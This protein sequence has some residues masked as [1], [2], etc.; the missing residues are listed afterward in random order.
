MGYAMRTD[1]YRYVQWRDMQSSDAQP[2]SLASRNF[3]VTNTVSQE[4]LYDHL[5]DPKENINLSANPAYD[6]L[7]DAYA[8]VVAEALS[9]GYSNVQNVGA[10]TAAA[11]AI[12]TATMVGDTDI[13][14]TLN[15]HYV[16]TDPN[17]DPDTGTT[18]EWVVDDAFDGSYSEVLGSG[19]SYVLQAADADRFIKLRVTPQNAVVPTTG[20][21]VYSEW[22]VVPA[23]GFNDGSSLPAPESAIYE[24][25]D[26]AAGVLNSASAGGR[27]WSGGWFGNDALSWGGNSGSQ[28]VDFTWSNLPAGYHPTPAGRAGGNGANAN[29]PYRGLGASQTI[30]LAQDST[31]YFSYLYQHNGSGATFEKRFHAGTAEVFKL[32][33]N[34]SGSLSLI[35]AD[36]ANMNLLTLDANTAYVIV[37]RLLSVASGNDS[38][39][40]SI[41]KAGDTV[42]DQVPVFSASVN[43]ASSATLDRIF[44]GNPFNASNIGNAQWDEFHMDSNYLAVVGTD[45]GGSGTGGTLTPPTVEESFDYAAG[46]ISSASAGGTGWN[47]GWFGNNDLNWGGNSGSAAADKSWNTP[48]GYNF[49]PSGRAATNSTNGN[50]PYRGLAAGTQIDLS[51]DTVY[52]SFLFTHAS[53]STFEYRFYAGATDVAKLQ[54][55]SSG[56]L[57]LVGAGFVPTGFN[58][59]AGNDYLIVGRIVGNASGDDL[60]QVTAYPASG[61][62]P[63]SEV[64]FAHSALFQSSAVIDRILMGIPG[65]TVTSETYWDELRMGSNWG[66]VL[67]VSDGNEPDPEPVDTAPEASRLGISGGRIAGATLQGHYLYSDLEN[68]EENGSSFR[69]LSADT[70]DGSYTA[71]SAATAQSYTLQA[72]DLGK[73]IRFEVTPA[74]AASQGAAGTAV[75]SSPVW[76]TNDISYGLQ[77]HLEFE[78]ADL[79]SGFADS[80]GNNRGASTGTGTLI[81]RG[82]GQALELNGIDQRFTLPFDGTIFDEGLSVAFWAKGDDTLMPNGSALAWTIKTTGGNQSNVWISPGYNN[83]NLMQIIM[84]HDGSG[85]EQSSYAADTADIKG[86]WTHWAFVKNVPAGTIE[87][88]KNGVLVNTATGNHTPVYVEDHW[89]TGA[90]WA[91]GEIWGNFYAGAIDDYRIYDRQITEGEVAQIHN[92]FSTTPTAFS[93]NISGNSGV[94]D[95]LTANYGFAY[96]LGT[97]GTSTYQWYRGDTEFGSFTAIPGATS[98]TYTTTLDDDG[99]FLRFGVTPVGNEGSTGP[100]ALSASQIIG[101]FVDTSLANS[102]YRLTQDAELNVVFFGGSITDGV[103]Q[104]NGLSWRTRTEN[105]LTSNFPSATINFTNAAISGTSSELGVFRTDRHVLSAQPDLVFV[106]FAVNDLEQTSNERTRQTMEGI[107]RKIRAAQ[108]NCDIVFVYTTTIAN[109]LN[110]YEND[111]LPSRTVIHQEVADHYGI[112]SIDVA[113]ALV[114]HKESS[115]Y[116]YRIDFG[117]PGAFDP[118][119]NHYLPDYVHPSNLGHQVYG[120]AVE[121]ALTTLL[122]INPPAALDP[123][124]TPELLSGYDMTSARIIDHTDAAVSYGAGWTTQDLGINGSGLTENF[125]STTSASTASDITVQFS[126]A[127][128]G[129]YYRRMTTGGAINWNVDTGAAQDTFSFYHATNTSFTTFALLTTGLSEQ[130]HE[131]VIQ[132]QAEPEHSTENLVIAGW[133]V[134][135]EASPRDPG[136]IRILPLGDS[137]T[138]GLSFGAANGQTAFPCGYRG[139]LQNLLQADTDFTNNFDVIGSLLSTDTNAQGAFDKSKPTADLLRYDGN[140]QGHSGYTTART[141]GTSPGNL[142]AVLNSTYT[143]QTFNPDIVLLHVGI[144]DIIA[145]SATAAELQTDYRSLVARIYELKPNVELYVST[146]MTNHPN[147]GQYPQIL[148]FNQA[149]RDVEIPYWES[150]GKSIQLVDMFAALEDQGYSSTLPSTNVNY[151]DDRV[152]PNPTGYAA[153]GTAWYNAIARPQTVSAPVLTYTLWADAAYAALPG[154]SNHPDAAPAAIPPGSSLNNLQIFSYGGDPANPDPDPD[155]LPKVTPVSDYPELLYYRR[156]DG[157]SA[158]LILHSTDLMANDWNSTGLTVLSVNPIDDT[159]E[160]LRV[161]AP[162]TLSDEP[163]QFFSIQV[164]S[165]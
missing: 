84:G 151:G 112:Y 159:R 108:P 42:P 94:G 43:V 146:L 1:R 134:L 119:A 102:L 116:P 95:T 17:G 62:V 117:Q 145:Q 164:E 25:F 64:P 140:H 70:V 161:R 36:E 92:L 41:Y 56:Q 28:A 103:G 98:L 22:A 127:E 31:H 136:A 60:L 19:S 79:S 114:A 144:N 72:S 12:L 115:G 53:T 118:A 16:Y 33:I 45:S 110:F 8:G 47:N 122:G 63:A 37:G 121:S 82:S 69:W 137:I 65:N 10:E 152:H 143:A 123:H 32:Q 27:G 51:A 86:A 48:T 162:Q 24:G 147:H 139:P 160:E 9:T 80:S 129:V 157:T 131:V 39:S 149:L 18:I 104:N 14:S 130:D 99:H 111:Q 38:L 5:T 3:T 35:S 11:P 155:L 154:G 49:T 52:F 83:G 78:D 40:V 124:P 97:E 66:S 101:I 67:G 128:L 150:Q 58:L 34:G 61:T 75:A 163:L 15:A 29:N 113:E 46:T 68:D 133:L 30:D 23:T 106:E 135:G 50:M 138:Y 156:I 55:D 89:A 125:L 87:V 13:G 26:Y 21:A 54:I 4:E 71:I 2:I 90:G 74:N 7:L 77:S 120:D 96:A 91:V 81:A 105:W 59:T 148:A 142:L 44:L 153:M 93:V 73:Y 165:D 107:V 6:A 57:R 126:G 132:P 88:Y 85:F 100:E 141:Y 158:P 109:A 76:L 20:T